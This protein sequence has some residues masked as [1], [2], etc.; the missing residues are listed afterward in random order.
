[1]KKKTLVLRER[2]NF[3]KRKMQSHLDLQII[4]NILEKNLQKMQKVKNL[5]LRE[6]KN[7]KAEAADLKN[8]YL[9]NIVKKEDNF[10]IF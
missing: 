6:R 9:K 10:K 3:L 5:V 2:K 1:M 7:L 4:L 8:L